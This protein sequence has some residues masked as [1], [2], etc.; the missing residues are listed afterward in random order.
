MKK[1]VKR[2]EYRVVPRAIALAALMATLPAA[3]A[4][5]LSGPDDDVA[6]SW[7][8][9]IRYGMAFR[10]KGQSPA[11]TGNPNADDGDRNFDK[12]LISNRLELL[13]E[14]DIKSNQGFGGRI[15][16]QGWYDTVYNRRNDNPGFAGGA[17]PNQTSVG[18]SDFTRT[19]RRLHGQ[20]LQLRDAFAFLNSDVGGKAVTVRLGQHA[21]VWG[22]SLFFAGN[23]IAGAQNR[24]DIARLQADPTAQAKE[25]VLPVPQL[26]G[27]IQVTPA[28]T[29]G[30]Y[31]QAEWKPNTFPAVGSYFSQGDLF[32]PGAENM[33]VGPGM[34]VPRT[35]DMKAKDSGQG[36]LQ[37]RWRAGDTD[38]G[39]YWMK[40]H[41]KTPQ[42]V[43]QLGLAGFGPG[44]PIA[45]PVGFY[46]AY[47]E[48]TKLL[49]ASA[50]HTFGDANFAI[51]A[52]FR[53]NQVLASSGG[54]VDA[55][56]LLNAL[57]PPGAAPT[58]DNAGNPAYA[59][60]NTAHVNVSTIWALT[61]NAL[62]RESNLVGEI[63]WN[64]VLS[65]R[66]H[67]SAP[68]PGIPA[69][70]D[71]NGKRDAWGL[72]MV[73]TPTYRQVMSGVDLSIPI[74]FSYSPK[75]GRSL[76]MGPGVLPPENGGDI[77]IGMNVVY[78]AT[79]HFNAAYTHF[80]GRADTLLS[81]NPAQATAPPYTY[82]QTLK[83]RDFL[84]LTLR[85]TF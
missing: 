10:A 68:A 25:F 41:D 61:P 57:L 53:R 47:H 9:T 55:T 1:C 78:D 31:Y 35:A 80:Y 50:S 2:T 12:G 37:L 70:L 20:D 6:M 15:S 24:F 62:F 23:G 36:G 46:Q 33:W 60:G 59:V 30:A 3:Y 18:A 54:T 82:G 42:I 40:F 7:N 34:A 72:R 76:A 71:P 48:N 56:P 65:C 32:G 64:R 29:I 79:W 19:T 66:K 22:E 63:A 39:L 73:F 58:V 4:V 69:A 16:A 44:G 14:F 84:M 51:E 13:T 5:E 45:M 28:V 21:L 77:T 75:G 83:D 38:Y 11:L 8:N 17:V 74:G 27:Q 52:S 26:S 43:T 81:S 67:C 85:R 49:G